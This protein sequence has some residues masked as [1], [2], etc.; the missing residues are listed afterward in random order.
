MWHM[1]K[2]FVILCPYCY[3]L[4]WGL[5]LM[6]LSPQLSQWR[7]LIITHTR[8]HAESFAALQIALCIS[9]YS[10]C[11]TSQVWNRITWKT[12]KNAWGAHSVIPSSGPDMLLMFFIM[13]FSFAFILCDHIEWPTVLAVQIRKFSSNHGYCKWLNMGSTGSG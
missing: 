5:W 7:K 12:K 8:M 2:A 3:A 10:M 9:C 4:K 11:F 1:K 13:V 6:L